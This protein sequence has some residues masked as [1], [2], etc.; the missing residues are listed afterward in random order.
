MGG[1]KKR[2]PTAEK[3][4]LGHALIIFQSRTTN[5]DQERSNSQTIVWRG[6]TGASIKH[7]FFN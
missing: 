1:E 6:W 2:D 5:E 4:E 7:V 3:H